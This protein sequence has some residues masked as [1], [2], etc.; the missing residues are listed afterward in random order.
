MKAAGIAYPVFFTFI[1]EKYTVITYIMVSD[2]AISTEAQVEAKL[3]TPYFSNISASTALEPLPDIGRSIIRGISS[4]GTPTFSPKGSRHPE[5]SST[6]P[7]ADTIETP[8]ISITKVGRSERE[9]S[10]PPF[11]PRK[12]SEV[13]SFF[14]KRI[15][16][17]EKRI[18]DGTAI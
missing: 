8:T 1:D 4:T 5:R 14:I 17:A 11:I 3:S 7:D 6:K 10:I 12:N 9:S 18:T 15:N 13:A 2:D 16:K